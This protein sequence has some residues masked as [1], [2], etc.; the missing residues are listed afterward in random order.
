MPQ[1]Q[2]DG[3]VVA[4]IDQW[5]ADKLLQ[6]ASARIGRLRPPPTFRQGIA[7]MPRSGR[8]SF[9]IELTLE[10]LLSP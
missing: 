7:D 9:P 1:L 3:Q 4:E 8:P 6:A 10:F 5:R 2:V